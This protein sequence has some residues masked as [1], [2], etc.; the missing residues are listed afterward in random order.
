MNKVHLFMIVFFVNYAILLVAICGAM[1]SKNEKVVDICG[2]VAPLLVL[3]Q[4]VILMCGCAYGCF[5]NM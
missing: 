5:K 4:I 2:R 1:W 3:A